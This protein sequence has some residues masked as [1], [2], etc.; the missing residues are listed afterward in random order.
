VLLLLPSIAHAQAAIT[1]VVRDTSGG[2]LPGASKPPARRWSRKFGRSSATTRPSTASLIC[3]QPVVPRWG[4]ILEGDRRNN[5][6]LRIAKIFRYGRTR[7][8]VGLEVYNLTNTDVVTNFNQTY[9]PNGAWL[10]PTEI[11][12]AR[13]MKISAQFDF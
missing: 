1:S 4:A 8:Q 2:V 3:A 13:Y 10:T 5:I 11:Q 9:V 6:D 12:P 7:T